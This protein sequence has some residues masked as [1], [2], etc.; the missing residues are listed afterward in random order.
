MRVFSAQHQKPNSTDT[1]GMESI[2][3]INLIWPW[4]Y[5]VELCYLCD[6]PLIHID[7][8]SSGST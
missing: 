1:F 7:L 2:V 6:R 5:A 8:D 3:Q 4:S